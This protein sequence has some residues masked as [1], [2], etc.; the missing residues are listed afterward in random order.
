MKSLKRI[1]GIAAVLLAWTA[2]APAGEPLSLGAIFGPRADEVVLR[3][4]PA[5]IDMAQ[6]ACD[7]TAKACNITPI[8]VADLPEPVRSE[9]EA[10]FPREVLD[11]AEL[12]FDVPLND[13]SLGIGFINTLGMIAAGGGIVQGMTFGDRVYIAASKD[14]LLKSAEWRDVLAHELVHV[15]QYQALGYEPYKEMYA[16][17][18]A[19][20][21]SYEENALEKEAF[22][23]QE[24]FPGH[25]DRGFFAFH[26]PSDAVVRALVGERLVAL[27]DLPE[28]DTAEVDIA[29]VGEPLA[30]KVT[31]SLGSTADTIVG[32][33][34]PQ[35]LDP[36]GG[37][38]LHVFALTGAA[39]LLS[40]E[41]VAPEGPRLVAVASDNGAEVAWRTGQGFRSQSFGP[42]AK[43]E[44]IDADG[45][46]EIVE[47]RPNGARSVWRWNGEGFQRN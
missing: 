15:A 43:V 25:V 23:F 45:T 5:A 28:L 16:K 44:D 34:A 20:M 18:T 19:R 24:R 8:S 17:E 11:K 13:P 40:N 14:T 42:T 7:A 37:Q 29:G 27:E 6:K 35:V 2:T 30:R 12:Y 38:P 41:N 22:L 33:T 36:Q 21:A 47:P 32:A 1:S 10:A 26:K 4:V 46:L 9:L 3:T 39:R 31:L